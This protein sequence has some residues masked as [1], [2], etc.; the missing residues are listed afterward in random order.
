VRRR[1]LLEKLT[2]FDG[3]VSRS[4]FNWNCGTPSIMAYAGRPAGDGNLPL[5]KGGK[6]VLI[7]LKS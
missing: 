4:R 1:R 7:Q 2:P 3:L 5:G 6:F